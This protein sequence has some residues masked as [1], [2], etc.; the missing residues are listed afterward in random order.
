MVNN[1]QFDGDPHKLDLIFKALSDSTRRAIIER[2]SASDALVSE[3]AEPLNMSLPAVSKH[4]GILEK[5]GL[6]SRE[7]KGRVRQCSLN[8][9]PLKNATDWIE[10]YKNFWGSRLNALDQYLR[11]DREE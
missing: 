2:L 7:K 4:L 3:L 9:G 10:F 5:A 1:K 8:V 6:L 11:K